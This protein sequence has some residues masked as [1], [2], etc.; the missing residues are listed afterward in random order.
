MYLKNQFLSHYYLTLICD[1]FY[2]IDDLDFASFANDNT[3]YSCL[4]DMIS[5]LGQLEGGINWFEKKKFLKE[6]I[7]NVT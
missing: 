4:G 6:I 3:P 2:S 1:L 5:V 7:I